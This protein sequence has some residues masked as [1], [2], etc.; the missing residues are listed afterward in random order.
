M[1]FQDLPFLLMNNLPSSA[2]QDR[3]IPALL[4]VCFCKS[5]CILS[6][7]TKACMVQC[8]RS[9][10]QAFFEL[11]DP[12]ETHTYEIYNIPPLWVDTNP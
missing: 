9:S 4:L 11:Q 8:V 6:S 1:Q 5:A 10:L 12:R 7:H 2:G 3:K